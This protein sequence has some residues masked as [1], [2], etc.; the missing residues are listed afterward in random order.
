MNKKELTDEQKILIHTAICNG[1]GITGAAAATRMDKRTLQRLI[2]N[3]ETGDAFLLGLVPPESI[4][5]EQYD[6]LSYS[7][8]FVGERMIYRDLRE[9]YHELLM[10]WHGPEI[11]TRLQTE[12][13]KEE[14]ERKQEEKRKEEAARRRAA[15]AL[16]E[17]E[18][19][20]KV[21]ELQRR[22]YGKSY[23]SI[24]PLIHAYAM[25]YGTEEEIEDGIGGEGHE[26]ERESRRL[27][28]GLLIGHNWISANMY[29]LTRKH[30][31]LETEARIIRDAEA[32]VERYRRL[33][34]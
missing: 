6:N 33:K 22:L 27:E 23:D 30:E 16:K 8:Y 11:M 12:A 26:A 2:E 5:R 21:E 20:E 4:T 9:R 3:P 32:L 10:K 34:G 1:K 28:R 31:K 7:G 24:Y 15:K 18:E 25:V 29:Q 17:A 19:W 14:E 13:E